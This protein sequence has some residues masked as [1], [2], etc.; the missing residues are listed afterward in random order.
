MGKT[1]PLAGN[2]LPKKQN[3][4]WAKPTKRPLCLTESERLSK[5]TMT[6]KKAMHMKKTHNK[7]GKVRERLE[8]TEEESS[9]EEK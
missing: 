8:A 5:E 7:R 4:S 1:R 9:R 6:W 3:S 2:S